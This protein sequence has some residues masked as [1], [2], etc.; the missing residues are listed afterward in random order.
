ERGAGVAELLD[1]VAS[2]QLAA[3]GVALAGALTAAGAHARQPLLEVGDQLEVTL[4]ERAHATT[5]ASTWRRPT[6]SPTATSSPWTVPPC[7]AAIDS[8]IF[9]DSIT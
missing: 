9:I 1:A 6:L 2:E 4:A 7:G 8:S 3:G 5:S